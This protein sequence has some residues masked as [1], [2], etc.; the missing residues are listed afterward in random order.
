MGFSLGD[1]YVGYVLS[2]DE[3]SATST[4]D[5]QD[6]EINAIAL[7]NFLDFILPPELQLQ[8]ESAGRASQSTTTTEP[9]SPVTRDYWNP[10]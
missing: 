7:E 3:I 5:N 9:D 1:E 4:Q 2:S 6:F 10:R 8:V